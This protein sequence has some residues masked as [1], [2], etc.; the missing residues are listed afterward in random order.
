MLAVPIVVDWE[1]IGILVVEQETRRPWPR[2]LRQQIQ[3]FGELVGYTLDRER[4][5]R[6]LARQNERLER[7]V[8]VVSHDLRNPLNVLSGYIELIEETGDPEHIED[9]SMAADRMETMIEDLLTLARQGE[10]LENASPSTS[11][12][13][14]GGP[15]TPSTRRMRDW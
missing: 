8:S 9:V 15:G 11:R 6:E 4:R 14:L 7:F 10:N 2:L 3:T 13:S 1:L 5:R 12:T